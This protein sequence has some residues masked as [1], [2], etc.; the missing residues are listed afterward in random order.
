MRLRVTQ[1]AVQCCV[2]CW[3]WGVGTA[4]KMRVGRFCVVL[5]FT[6]LKVCPKRGVGSVLLET[7]KGGGLSMLFGPRVHETFV[8]VVVSPSEGWVLYEGLATVDLGKKGDGCVCFGGTPPKWWLSFWVSLQNDL[9]PGLFFFGQSLMS[10]RLI[11][12][13]TIGLGG[14]GAIRWL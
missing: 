2:G 14:E 9:S 1:A 4:K 11:R 5:A 6:V 3:W 8:R 13:I 7:P 12:A 10:L